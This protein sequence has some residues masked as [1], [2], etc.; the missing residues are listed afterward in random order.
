MSA[1]SQT[2]NGHP[3]TVNQASGYDGDGQNVR[4]IQTRSN[5]SGYVNTTYYLRSSVLGGAIVEEMDGS[6]QK[7]VG[8]V[9]YPGGTLLGTQVGG[10]VVWKHA[11][12]AGTSRYDTNT[13]SSSL[14]RQ[15]FDPLGA[16][17][18]LTAPPQ[19]DTG[20]GDGDIGSRHTGGLRSELTSD[21]FNP[22]GGCVVDGHQES[23]GFA[24][25]F[26]NF[27]T[28]QSTSMLANANVTMQDIANSLGTIFQPAGALSVTINV[29]GTAGTP[30]HGSIEWQWVNYNGQSTFAPVPT[31]YSG[32]AEIAGSVVSL[33]S[34]FQSQTEVANHRTREQSAVAQARTLLERSDC[35]DF[36]RALVRHAAEATGQLNSIKLSLGGGHASMT[37]YNFNSFSGLDAYQAAIDNGWVRSLAE[38]GRDYAMTEGAEG[39]TLRLT[40]TGSFGDRIGELAKHE[41]TWRDSFYSAT[42]TEAGQKTL[43]E[44]LHQL[45]GFTDQVLANAARYAG[46][47]NQETYGDS[48]SETLRASRDLTNLINQ[49]CR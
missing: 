15:E 11:T 44:S 40:L 20:G 4:E 37:I 39:E 16:D 10:S 12:P 43:H 42:L 46:G 23:C 27:G 41:V 49:H 33:S 47:Q 7:N 6:G 35:V 36:M 48:V 8:Y 31:A 19:P 1:Q 2:F 38:R 9:Y 34:S 26:V 30:G 28:G 18:G 24:M 25:M 21:I 17:V 29:S 32:I 22:S 3:Y 5:S 13:S 45:P 14:N